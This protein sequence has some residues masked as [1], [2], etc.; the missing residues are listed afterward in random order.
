MIM[1]VADTIIPYTT[2]REAIMNFYD[3]YSKA[4]FETEGGMRERINACLAVVEKYS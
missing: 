4:L 2:D 3:E 1:E